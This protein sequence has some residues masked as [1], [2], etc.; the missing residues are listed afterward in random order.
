MQSQFARLW[1]TLTILPK[2]AAFMLLI[3]IL[4]SAFAFGGVIRSLMIS[5]ISDSEGIDKV[6]PPNTDAYRDMLG[7][8]K[9]TIL[10][11]SP[12]FLPNKNLDAPE[13][14][15][16]E[17]TGLF[18]TPKYAGP[19]LIGLIGTRAY[20]DSTLS[21]NRSDLEVGQGAGSLHLISIEAP[22]TANVKW[23]DYTY[24]LKLMDTNNLNLGSGSNFGSN[25]F[26]GN[27]GADF[28]GNGRSSLTTE[29][30]PNQR[31]RGGPGGRSGEATRGLNL[32][33]D[34]GLEQGQLFLPADDENP[35]ED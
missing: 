3:A 4:V 9:Q 34:I 31:G 11:R 23:K 18:D 1:K 13:L 6:P 25:I 27:T 16:D 2:V 8:Y 5:P 21:N 10:C 24:S 35:N 26:G 12:F 14:P 28:L 22:W 30:I 32:N 19:R 17:P 15:A 33:D 20:F 7:N 29:T